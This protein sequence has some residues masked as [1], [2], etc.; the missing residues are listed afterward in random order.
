MARQVRRH[1]ARARLSTPS[2]QPFTLVDRGARG[3]RFETTLVG[4]ARIRESIGGGSREEAA[5]RA[6]ERIEELVKL[7]SSPESPTLTRTAAELIVAKEKAGNA[8]GYLNA[9]EGH[10]RNYVLPHYGPDVS[11][12]AISASE[13]ARFKHLLG[14]GDL[15]LRSCNRVLTTLRQVFKH[16]EEKGY[17]E[18]HAFP[19]NFRED[20]QSQAERW[21]ILQPEEIGSLLA[22][23]DEQIRPLLGFIANTG[24]RIGT[25]LQTETA[26]I[27]WHRRLVH[28]PASAMKGRRAHTVEL[29]ASSLAFLRAALATSATKPFP[30]TYWY[31]IKRWPATR[32]A[33]G[34]PGLRIHD[35]RHSFVSNQL[36]AGT[37]IH[38]VR[39]MAAHRSLTVTAL[40]AHQ[41]DEAR[42]AAADR[43]QI[44]VAAKPLVSANLEKIGTR[45]GTKK[46]AAPRKYAESI[47]GQEGFEPSA[48]GLRIHCSTN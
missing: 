46:V 30:Y 9:I 35:L 43:L 13:H 7:A 39:D 33:A 20:P 32:E 34:F 11:L 27:D 19:R 26:W 45:F 4:Q 18:P 40:Y 3:F 48:N 44:E 10:L 23:A 36:A 24:L 31:V 5:R 12:R 14:E 17:C 25:A 21:Q 6:I 2:G 22:H 28:Y 16:G 41:T 47:V 15:D 1:Q 38:V 8:E 42:R 29:N 37:P